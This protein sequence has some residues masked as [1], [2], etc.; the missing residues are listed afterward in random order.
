MA[1][2]GGGGDEIGVGGDTS[3][4]WNVDVRNLRPRTVRSDQ[5]GTGVHQ[6]GIAETPDGAAFTIAIK[7]PRDDKGARERFL[8]GV[9]KAVKAPVGDTIVFPLPIEPGNM[10]CK[11][12]KVDQIRITWPARPV[13]RTPRAAGKKK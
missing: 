1:N 11:T 3:V 8:A 6:E 10:D 13:G 12:G 7:L 9:L 2:F 5:E 4:R